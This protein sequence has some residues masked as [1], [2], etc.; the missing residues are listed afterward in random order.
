MVIAF[1][2]CLTRL[3]SIFTLACFCVN[4]IIVAPAYAQS[5]VV[6]SAPGAMVNTSPSFQAPVLKGV[7]VYPNDPFRFDF[8]LDKGDD[9]G[10]VFDNSQRDIAA[11]LIKYFLAALAIA[12]S[13]QW[14]NLSP[15]E[16]E[17]II[18]D[19][20]GVTEMGRDLLA[21]D[22]LLKQIT[23]SLT[24]PD[25]LL[26]KQ[27]WDMAYERAYNKF[28]TTDIPTNILSKVW[29]IPDKAVVYEKDSAVYVLENHLKVMLDSDYQAM[30]N[31]GADIA[32][33]DS[34]ALKITRQVM[35]EVIVPAIEKEV[36]EGKN[37][38]PVRQA[39]SGM[40]LATWYKRSLKE[41]IL[42]KLYADQGKVK[43]VE[44]DDPARNREIYD[45]YV[46]AFKK[47]VFNIIR[48]DVERYTKEVIPRQYFSGGLHGYEA[49]KIDQV[50]DGDFARIKNT[51]RS[52]SHVLVQVIMANAGAI[53]ATLA[54]R[55]KQ[56]AKVAATAAVFSWT[57]IM[58]VNELSAGIIMSVGNF[59]AETGVAPSVQNPRLKEIVGQFIST[60][61]SLST[62]LP[63]STV[64]RMGDQPAVRELA[65]EMFALSAAISDSEVTA[66]EYV[67]MINANY[68]YLPVQDIVLDLMLRLGESRNVTVQHKLVL[69]AV[70]AFE[71]EVGSGGVT[72]A[73]HAVFGKHFKAVLN[74]E[75]FKLD[76]S[77]RPGIERLLSILEV[78]FK[79]ETRDLEWQEALRDND[80][81]TNK[82]ALLTQATAD[83][84]KFAPEYIGLWST[85]AI[86]IE[87]TDGWQEMPGQG[88]MMPDGTGRTI[89]IARPYNDRDTLLMA[90]A[91]KVYDGVI[92]GK[93]LES[94]WLKAVRPNMISRNHY[95]AALRYGGKSAMS[96]QEAALVE[97]EEARL[98][99]SEDAL[100][101]V[102]TGGMA[103]IHMW[104]GGGYKASGNS[105]KREEYL[106]IIFPNGLKEHHFG[107]ADR[108]EQLAKVRKAL[109]IVTGIGRA[110]GIDPDLKWMT[111]EVPPKVQFDKEPNTKDPS[112]AELRGGI[113][114]AQAGLDMQI[115]RDGQGIVL[116]L[117]QQNLE[118]IKIDGLTPIILNIGSAADISLF[119]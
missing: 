115:M 60:S 23:S 82:L 38:T 75:K 10:N 86:S 72:R 91:D 116:P 100:A 84:K 80:N 4:S 3:V 109:E 81:H 94:E 78:L 58:S 102:T 69:K 70:E 39:Y 63:V 83:F 28:G 37:F 35:R 46:T 89:R 15:Y 51:I 25:T 6:L 92:K 114:F 1:S 106:R 59:S 93:S 21:Q 87:L 104:D 108:D 101:A 5:A 40:L 52:V 56:W 98:L 67:R 66:I 61:S 113:D 76:T 53:K 11:R 27:F 22:Y 54:G 107:N 41:T 85:N 65:N 79:G 50:S 43:G 111:N 96:E 12:D 17:R 14:V 90:M 117:S 105:A 97:A 45:Q 16:Q 99:F 118:N 49:L 8:I 71:R 110:V 9:A 77:V 47:G 30:Q 36:N 26:G 88:R 73:T 13:D 34:E 2:K 42:G 44:Q 32:G 119:K 18:P 55:W 103:E 7:Q 68:W 33:N 64:D 48:E 74:S 57:G 112:E 62:A 95:E 24:N 29:I 19:A 20:F 31:S